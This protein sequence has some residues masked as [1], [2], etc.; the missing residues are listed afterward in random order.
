M[1]VIQPVLVDGVVNYVDSSFQRA[2]VQIDGTYVDYPIYK[3]QKN[4]NILRK[5]IYLELEE[6]FVGEAQLLG[7]DNEVLAKKPFSIEKKK[8]GLLLTFQITITVREG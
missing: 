1:A 7:A 2:R 6:G 3:T 8:D 4:G 5:Q